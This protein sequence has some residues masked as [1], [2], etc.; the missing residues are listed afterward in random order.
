MKIR[1]L[2]QTEIWSRKTTQ[3]LVLG[4]LVAGLLM[5]FGLKAWR[6]YQ[7][8]WLTDN[9]RS[10]ARIALQEIDKVRLANTVSWEDLDVIE[11]PM[12]KAI[13]SADAAAFT[14]RDQ[15]TVMQVESCELEMINERERAF[16]QQIPA[17]TSEQIESKA[18]LLNRISTDSN[19]TRGKC[20]ALRKA[21]Y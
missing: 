1:E 7:Y 14:K 18:K 10:T 2:L 19:L 12:K 17:S 9:E 20:E 6:S 4:I 5:V 15:I 13:A 3:R 21:L 16:L 8:Y 11:K